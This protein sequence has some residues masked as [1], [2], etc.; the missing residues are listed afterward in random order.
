MLRSRVLDYVHDGVEYVRLDR[1]CALPDFRHRVLGRV[2]ELLH[3]PP[4]LGFLL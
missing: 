1:N 2:F 3:R 4:I